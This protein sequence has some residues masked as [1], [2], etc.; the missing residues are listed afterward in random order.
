MQPIDHRLLRQL[1]IAVLI[2]IIVLTALWWAFVRDARVSV[3][4][5]GVSDRISGITS[6]QGARK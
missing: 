5:D 1:I 6:S 4:G 3:D 2:K